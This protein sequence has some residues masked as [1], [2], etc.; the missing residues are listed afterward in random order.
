MKRKVLSTQILASRDDSAMPPSP[1]L[2]ICI[3]IAIVLAFFLALLWLHSSYP[4]GLR[5]LRLLNEAAPVQALGQLKAEIQGAASSFI[6]CAVCLELLLY[7]DDVRCLPCRHI[8]HA[9]CI[10]RWFLQGQFTCPCCKRR[11]VP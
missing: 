9:S 7:E 3:L 6:V 4:R 1:W 11:L 8:F 5:G 10:N 2:P